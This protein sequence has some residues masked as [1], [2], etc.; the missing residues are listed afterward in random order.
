M[1]AR[2]PGLICLMGPGALAQLLFKSRGG[3]AMNSARIVNTFL[4]RWPRYEYLR[5]DLVSEANLAAAQCAGKPDA[6]VARAVFHALQRFAKR[7]Y[8]NA[9]EQPDASL[10]YTVPEN[11]WD[12]L[13]KA[14]TDVFDR[15]LIELRAAGCN[16]AEVANRLGCTA[17]R[18]GRRRRAIE[19][20][21]N[22]L[23]P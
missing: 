22:L 3:A 6:Y 11:L 12:N 21:Y 19:A 17:A 9:H 5:D 1:I 15:K 23:R 20:N 10:S 16:D 7:E 2:W 8:S 14:C 13:L 4:R 18:V